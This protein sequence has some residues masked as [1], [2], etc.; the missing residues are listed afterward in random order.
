MCKK[1]YIPWNKGVKGLQI[2]WNKGISPSEELR[3]RISETLKK[4]GI[5]PPS[6]LGAKLTE[7]Q[8]LECASHFLG[9][10]HSEEAK[11]KI[12][13]AHTGKLV[14]EDTRK[15]LSRVFKG[16]EK[17]KTAYSFPKGELNPM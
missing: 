7:S 5:K 2:A 14:L 1:G 15:K 3:K 6:R 10:N 8:K 11:R 4:K 13:L 17:T 9:K 12:G 16:K